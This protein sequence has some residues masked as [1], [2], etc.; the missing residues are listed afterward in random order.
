M[1]RLLEPDVLP[2]QASLETSHS[3]L[4]I[5]TSLRHRTSRLFGRNV[6][7]TN[8]ADNTPQAIQPRPLKNRHSW[9]HSV[10]AR[11]HRRDHTVLESSESSQDF[12]VELEECPGR[13]NTPSSPET[14]PPR[15]PVRRRFFRSRLRLQSLPTK[16]R[17]GGTALFRRASSSS[18][19]DEDKENFPVPTR[20]TARP[21]DTPNTGSWSSF[22]SGVQRAVRGMWFDRPG[23]CAPTV[24][25]INGCSEV[26]DGN[27]RF[28]DGHGARSE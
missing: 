14:S 28:S 6:A 8:T 24:A 19:S 7:V 20:P 16:F 2:D 25:D 4:S 21:A 15:S 12:Q 17:R 10:G 5:V 23:H 27:F 3:R 9:F 26:A 18:F 13:I 11:F 1:S 22:R